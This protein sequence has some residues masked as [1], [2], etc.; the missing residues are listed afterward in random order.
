MFGLD[1][2]S[3]V[4]SIHGVIK[5]FTI[6]S[7]PFTNVL[8]ASVCNFHRL[9]CAFFCKSSVKMTHI[10]IFQCYLHR[11]VLCTICPRDNLAATK[12]SIVSLQ[13]TSCLSKVC[14][15][16]WVN[17]SHCSVLFWICYCIYFFT[18]YTHLSGLFK[19]Y[20]G[21]KV[22]KAKIIACTL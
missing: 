3:I 20:N 8:P 1:W 7:W 18:V 6:Y 16:F 22:T 2:T 13:R 11:G 19:T 14:T 9:F 17:K 15:I 21:F 5:H 12:T 10:Y 4:S